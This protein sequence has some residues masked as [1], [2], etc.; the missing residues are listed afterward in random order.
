MKVFYT[1][2]MFIHTHNGKTCGSPEALT[3][4]IVFMECRVKSI[5]GA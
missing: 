5:V 3:T 2:I 4:T 1:E